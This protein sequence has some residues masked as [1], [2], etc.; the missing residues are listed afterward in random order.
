MLRNCDEVLLYNRVQEY[1][2][3]N[4]YTI[5]VVSSEATTSQSVLSGNLE[6]SLSN[7]KRLVT[8]ARQLHKHT[9]NLH[10]TRWMLRDIH[11]HS[12]YM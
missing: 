11:L 4:K 2:E 1:V 8:V 6:L 12:R 3:H 10:K 9:N 7:K 5:L